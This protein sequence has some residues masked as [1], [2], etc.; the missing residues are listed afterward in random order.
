M[1][2]VVKNLIRLLSFLELLELDIKHVSS[3]NTE[4]D[5]NISRERKYNPKLIWKCN[6]AKPAF[7]M[8]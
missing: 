7:R 6:A 3:N 4:I 8:K 5:T 2:V 1:V